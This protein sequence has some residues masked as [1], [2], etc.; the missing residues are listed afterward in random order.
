MKP[1]YH[2]AHG[3]FP[4]VSAPHNFP[5]TPNPFKPVVEFKKIHEAATIPAPGR[6][7]DIGF[8]ITSAERVSI[9]AGMTKKVSSGLVLAN[10]TAK[11]NGNRI[12]MK[13]EG[14]SGMSLKGVFPVGGIIDPTYRGEIGIVLTNNS[15]QMYEINPGDRIA[16][17]VVYQVAT[18]EEISFREAAEVTQ[19]V[20]GDQGFGSSGK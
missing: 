3:E 13:V 7:G 8:D 18:A 14:R 5:P 10:M 20:R 19:T 6:R 4:P 17:L 12:F 11:V 2:N 16:Q 9:G 1:L 15:G